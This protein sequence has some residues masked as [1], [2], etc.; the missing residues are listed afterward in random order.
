MCLC[1]GTEQLLQGPAHNDPV[2]LA[3]ASGLRRCFGP[4]ASIR[5]AWAVFW[6][7]GIVNVIVIILQVI[8][9]KYLN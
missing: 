1:L 2:P 4:V 3:I 6:F 5:L 9:P 8:P 7:T